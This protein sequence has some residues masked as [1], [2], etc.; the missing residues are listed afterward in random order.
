VQNFEPGKNGAP[1]GIVRT[2]VEDTTGVI[3]VGSTEGLW[4]FRDEEWTPVSFADA[5]TSTDVVAFYED[6]EKNLWLSTAVGIFRRTAGKAEFEALLPSRRADAFV[7]SQS[8]ELLVTGPTRALARPDSREPI[9][10]QAWARI[11][12]TRLTSDR[13][14]NIWIATGGRGLLRVRAGSGGIGEFV[15]E[16]HGLTGDVVRSLLEDREGN[17]WVGTQNGLNRLTKRIVV[18]IPGHGDQRMNRELRAMTVGPDGRVW[19]GSVAG[20]YC[21]EGN[22]LEY[23]VPQ[24]LR[25]IRV[26]ALHSGVKGNI[27]AATQDGIAQVVGNRLAYLPITDGHHLADVAFIAADHHGAVWIGAERLFRWKSRRVVELS[28]TRPSSI[29]VDRTNRVWVGFFDGTL[30]VYDKDDV[31]RYSARDGLAGGTVSTVFED[32]QG[33]IWV[34]TTDGLSRFNGTGFDTITRVNGLPGHIVESII[35]DQAGDLWIAVGSGIARVAIAEF[36]KAVANRSSGLHHTLYDSFDG[37]TGNPFRRGFPAVVRAGD[38]TLWFF[39][40]HGIA[41]VD[42]RRAEKGRLPPPVRVQ[43]ASA[44]GRELDAT[45]LTVLPAGTSRIQIDY[46]ALSFTAPSKVTFRYRLEGFDDDWVNAF[47]RRQAFYTNLSPGD[48][49]FS[50]QANNDGVWSDH[51][52]VWTFSVSPA[53]YQTGWFRMLVALFFILTIC[54]AWWLRGRRVQRRFALVLAERAR[55]AREIHD[56]LLQGFVG[57]S[58]QYNALSDEVISAPE[59]AKARCERLRERV[60][61]LVREARHTI[62]DLRS[63]TLEAVD[64][65]TALR[66]AGETLVTARGVA[67]DF[68]LDGQS[69]RLRCPRAEQALLRIGYEALSNAVRHAAATAVRM[70]LVFDSDSVTLRVADNGQGFNPEDPTFVIEHH[71]GL[72]IMQERAHEIGGHFRLETKLGAGTKIEASVPISA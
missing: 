69:P 56:T 44:D 43:L 13:E 18:S 4:R 32:D 6:R 57:L 26:S 34:G 63:P 31:K 70:E 41:I 66:R 60:E 39:T 17:I 14:G 15:T 9:F 7:E 53:V 67:F 45:S 30:A 38:G 25:G 65:A 37:I 68:H 50:V 22:S 24:A 62:W 5:D 20:A 61:T 71:W 10:Q 55:I 42:P 16:R 49:R 35:Q 59:A 19:V 2:I 58:L 8:G 48:Y 46:T 12:G 23:S 51:V 33:K 40:S 52:A 47:T 29:R 36:D 64:L 54:S 3:W 72:G 1:V 21:F 27:W 11:S 28:S